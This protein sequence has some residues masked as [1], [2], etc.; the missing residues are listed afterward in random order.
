MAKTRNTKK[1]SDHERY[2]TRAAAAADEFATKFDTPTWSQLLQLAQGLAHDFRITHAV[3]L[4]AVLV[5]ALAKVEMAREQ[6][7]HVTVDLRDRLL[8]RETFYEQVEL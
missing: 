2:V 4:A 5:E 6:A 1:P 7:F 8:D 3:V